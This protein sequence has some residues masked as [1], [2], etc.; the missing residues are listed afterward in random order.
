MAQPVYFPISQWVDSPFPQEPHRARNECWTWVWC[1]FLERH[2]QTFTI[3]GSL[4]RIYLSRQSDI[5]RWSNWHFSWARKLGPA[6]RQANSFSKG[7]RVGCWWFVVER[8]FRLVKATIREACGIQIIPFIG[9]KEPHLG[10]GYVY[11]DGDGRGLQ[12][13]RSAVA[14]W[15]GYGQ[16]RGLWALAGKMTSM[17]LMPAKWVKQ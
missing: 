6:Q 2:K 4:S 9:N 1:F 14:G 12:L 16:L 3:Y 15:L 7:H 5:Q 11:A 13:W 8:Y 17:A 10:C